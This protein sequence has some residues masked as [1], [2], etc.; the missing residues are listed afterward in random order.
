[1]Q[2]VTNA[3]TCAKV[4]DCAL[5]I[6]AKPV[7]GASTPEEA[8]EA[9]AKVG[10]TLLNFGTPTGEP[11]ARAVVSAAVVVVDPVGCGLA[12]R[13]A[14]VKRWLE[15]RKEYRKEHR[16][17]GKPRTVHTVVKGNAS[18]MAALM[19]LYGLG[20]AEAALLGATGASVSATAEAEV[21]AARDETME[22]AEKRDRVVMIALSALSGALDAYVVMTGAVDYG[23][24]REDQGDTVWVTREDNCAVLT[25]FSGAGCC[26]GG[27]IAAFVAAH[28][29]GAAKPLSS[30]RNS[31]FRTADRTSVSTPGAAY[32]SPRADPVRA[33]CA[34]YRRV[35]AEVE[36]T[37][38]SSPGPASF[39]A[40]FFDALAQGAGDAGRVG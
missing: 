39:Q 32:G 33:A 18:E 15:Y 29:L 10:A 13:G 6:G 25:R 37:M 9:C 2:L 28:G 3:A 16:K 27:V 17:G 35:A 23:V 14:A 31:V 20:E 30:Y 22:E 21:G 40:A 12:T 38:G 1:V 26:L 7:M 24:P 8:A 11:V 4:V 34:W 5:A 36:A 19:R